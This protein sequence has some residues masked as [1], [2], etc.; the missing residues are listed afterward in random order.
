V[1]E[2]DIISLCF[3]YPSLFKL[4]LVPL[5]KML[6]ESVCSLVV[7]LELLYSP[8]RYCL[9]VLSKSW[10]YKLKDCGVF[11]EHGFLL[12]QYYVFSL[13]LLLSG[14]WYEDIKYHEI[15]VFSKFGKTF[16]TSLLLNLK[17]P[18]WTLTFFYIPWAPLGVCQYFGF[19]DC[20]MFKGTGSFTSRT[21]S[22][23]N[24][25]VP[26]YDEFV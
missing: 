1:L 23:S 20:G 3:E 4:T 8:L 10:D 14:K 15:S 2:R 21:I 5:Y 17:S 16:V 25:C 12:F 18:T 26:L 11:K 6:E 22:W 7:Y 9:M 19:N 13:W 24:L